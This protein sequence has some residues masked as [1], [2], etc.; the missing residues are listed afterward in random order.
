MALGRARD[1]AACHR[2]SL[3]SDSGLDAGRWL[4]LFQVG[5]RLCAID[6]WPAK[7]LD[8]LGAGDAEEPTALLSSVLNF[9]ERFAERNQTNSRLQAEAAR[10]YFKVG[11]LLERLDRIEEAERALERAVEMFEE[12]VAQIPERG[13][14]PFEDRRNRDHDR[15]LV[16]RSASLLPLGRRLRRARELVDQLAA[17]NPQYLEY[18]QSQIH[19]Y[20]KLGAVMQRLDRPGDAESAYR[21]AIE[22][23]GSLMERSSSPARATIDRADVREALAL[24]VLGERAKRRGTRAAGRRRRRLAIAARL[25]KRLADVDREV[26]EPGRGIPKAW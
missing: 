1:W 15:S 3:P 2:V 22:F 19:V 4:R 7:V 23:A 25:A 6:R 18:V 5:T 20:A 17:G 9:Y 8:L 14:V 26:R 10:A 16:G 21:R 24:L 11:S 13:R 12:L